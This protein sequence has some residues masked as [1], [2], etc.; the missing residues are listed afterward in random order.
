[1][2]QELFRHVLFPA[3]E[4]LVAR[5]ETP[6]YLA[7]YERSQW[8]PRAELEALQLAKLNALLAHCWERVPFLQRHWRAAGLQPG[9]LGSVAEL[10]RY[11]RLTK[12]DITANYADCIASDWR[13][14][15]LSKSTGGSSGQPF[16]FEIT[17][18]SYARR[19]ALMWR[20]YA[21]G[22]AAIGTRTAYLWG[23]GEPRRGLAGL[24][25]SAYHRAFNRRFFNAFAMREDTLADYVRG[26]RAYRPRVLVGY[27][28]PVLRVA[29]WLNA[30]G[31]RIEG[32]RGV[33]T[34]AEALYGP[35]REE[36]ERA[37]GVP[38]T[39]TYGSREVM[40][41]ASECERHCGL[42]VHIDHLVLETVDADGRG[43]RGRSGEVL[44]TDL[45][46]YGM[47]L[48]RYANGD[49]ATPDDAAC[50]C[51][52]ALPLLASVDGRVLETIVTPDGR[53]LPGEFFV[54]TMVDWPRVKQYLVVQTA[55][56]AVELQMVVS[57]ALGPEEHAALRERLQRTVGGAMRVTLREVASIAPHPS[58]KRR[59]TVALAA[60]SAAGQAPPV[61]A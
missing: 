53:I 4:K 29:R 27:V 12:A 43:V 44:V 32:L 6:R 1:M 56:D 45:H 61:R 17:M 36:I 41:M 55:P 60:A 20:S 10:E 58:G 2:Y 11:P 5:R 19:T 33:I 39:N 52:R 16:R 18:E 15:T 46:N 26:M 38:V 35:E 48:V 13:G 54:H 22:G 37:F 14:R 47:P 8:L 51:G 49:R 23:V 57:P 59:I 7:D 21:W 3:W 28:A 50:D 40:L 30:R 9:P 42:H 34:G 24:K 25:E 31:E